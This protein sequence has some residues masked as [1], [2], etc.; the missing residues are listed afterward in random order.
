MSAVSKGARE[1]LDNTAEFAHA[2][3]MAY[4]GGKSGSGVY[5]AIINLMPPHEVYIEPF[6]GG[7]AIMRLKRPAPVNIGVDSNKDV[8]R[9]WRDSARI[10][11]VA[12]GIG[13]IADGRYLQ[14]RAAGPAQLAM[15]AGAGKNGDASRVAAVRAVCTKR[16]GARRPSKLAMPPGPSFEFHQGCGIEFLKSY[17]WQGNELVYCDPPYVRS[18]RSDRDRLYRHEM[19]DAEHEELLGVLATLPCR[20]MVSAYWSK[21]Y[22]SALRGWN[23]TTYTSN[24]RQHKTV[25]EWLWCNFSRPVELHDYRYLGSDYRERERIKKKVTRWTGKLA[26][27]PVLERQ[28][29]LA[30]IASTAG[31]GD[32]RGPLDLAVGDRPSPVLALGSATA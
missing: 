30:A 26:K 31:S 13:G 17:P 3:R 29:L 2:V 16:V 27:M 4:P 6:L 7:G 21:L 22:A 20:V 25:P 10:A 14:A 11:G 18:S 24:L 23:N 32:T 9:L 5:Q 15:A 28:A 12:G 8:I 19:T 1:G